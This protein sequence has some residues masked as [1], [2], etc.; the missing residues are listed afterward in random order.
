LTN[1]ADRLEG[2]GVQSDAGA[3]RWPLKVVEAVR[4]VVHQS[5]SE[6]DASAL[7][8]AVNAGLVELGDP[9]S[10]TARGRVVLARRGW[11]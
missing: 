4:W 2:A 6:P 8:A 11:L 5:G 9:W 3:D 10:L 7:I 1:P